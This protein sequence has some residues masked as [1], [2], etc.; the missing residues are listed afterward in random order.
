M[1]AGE[2]LHA[3]LVIDAREQR[4]A[5]QGRGPDRHIVHCIP[6]PPFGAAYR[7][8]VFPGVVS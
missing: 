8:L 4:G 3:L 7:A 2:D 6:P 5:L 1:P